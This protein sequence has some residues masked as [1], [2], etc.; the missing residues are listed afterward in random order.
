M[1]VDKCIATDYKFSNVLS[2][3]LTKWLANQIF[4]VFLHRKNEK[5]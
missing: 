4:Y 3:F 5:R 1:S 2:I